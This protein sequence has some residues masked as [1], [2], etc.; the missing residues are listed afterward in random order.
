M[1]EQ[2]RGIIVR[3][4]IGAWNLFNFTRRFVFGVIALF[5]LIGFIAALRTST[6]KLLDK[7]ALVLDP[8][9]AIVEQYTND[10]AQRALS[11]LAGDKTRQTQLRD[12][13]TAID[14]AAKDPRIAR[15]VLKPDDIESVGLATSHEIGAALD[16]FKATGKQVIAVSD[17]MS[18]GQYYLAVHANQIL[19]HPESMEGVLLTGFGAYRSYYKDAL[20]WLGVDVH[21]FKVGT[22]KSYPEP[23]VRND[24]S[25]ESK[26]ADLFWMN[27]LW[28]DYLKDVAAARHQDPAKISAL[29][30]GYADAVKA[31][32][33]DMAKLA[34][35]AKL[36]DK[37]ATPDEARQLL[38][39]EGARD[40]HTY[41]HI[42]FADYAALV[43]RRLGDRVKH[44]AT[45]NE[46]SVFT[47]FGYAMDWCAP[48][49]MDRTANLRAIHHLNLAHGRG[50]DV[51]RDSVRDASIGAI[52]NRQVVRPAS[53]SEADRRAAEMLDAHWNLAFP[54]PQMRAAYPPLLAEAIEPWVQAGDMAQICRRLDWIHRGWTGCRPVSCA[55]R[56]TAR[57]WHRASS[58]WAWATS[59]APMPLCMSTMCWR[60]ATCDG[61][62][63]AS[64]CGMPTLPMRWGRSRAMIRAD[65][66]SA[67]TSSTNEIAAA[68]L[69][70]STTSSVPHTGPYAKPAPSV[71]TEPG[72]SATAVSA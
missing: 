29:I 14:A 26:E 24:A 9:G 43:S 17:G 33:G 72:T 10:A 15:I 20:D 32:G 58:T 12:I 62:S 64:A 45:F 46:F 51:L 13:I 59:F 5:L 44:W 22:F 37:L 67:M 47:L 30:A 21:V 7:T 60:A 16:R 25:P 54:E 23:Y 28:G 19:L 4:F 68:R 49:L 3:F 39:D 65:T 52:H 27:D 35:A 55:P 63:T 38:I 11:N 18:Q 50:V 57:N 36:V 69:L 70:P 1:A 48:G 61:A 8:K 40:G 31:A 6:P 71:S 41:R 56:T 2:Q 42:D 66:P 34:L 53:P